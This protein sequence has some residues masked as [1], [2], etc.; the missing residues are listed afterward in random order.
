M[1]KEDLQDLLMFYSSTEKKMVTLHEYVS[2]MKEGQKYVYF[3]SGESVEKIDMLPQTELVKD[4]GYEILYFTEDVD[5]FAIR[6]L[7]KYEEKE[8]KSV[9]DSD[10]GIEEDKKEDE[11]E[12]QEDKKLFDAMKEALSDKV[13]E[14]RASSRLKSHPVCLVSGGPLSIE[15]EKVLNSMPNAESVNAEK[16]LEINRNHEIFG[17]LKDAL[18]N[19]PEKLKLYTRLLYNQALLME[20]LS[21]EDPLAFSNEI[22]ELMK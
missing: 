21:V 1:N 10:L 8:F 3:A 19:D 12:Q 20:G 6:V 11:A 4:K 7:T 9:S 5:E 13:K 2:R 22:C 18:E 16:V 15:M 17:T 14:V